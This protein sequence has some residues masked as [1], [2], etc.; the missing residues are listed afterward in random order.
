M[1]LIV[2]E[3]LEYQDLRGMMKPTLHVDEFASKMGDD[4]DIIVLSFFL[5]DQFAARDLMHW[6][7][8]GYDWVLDADVSPGEIRPN[9][10]LVYV[11]MRRRSTAGSNIQ[12]M[13]ED[14][15]TLTELKPS[16]WIMHYRDKTQPFSQEAFDATVPL[17]PREY[18]RQR[19]ESNNDIRTL[20]GIE[21]KSL[22]EPD[23]ELR[24]LQAAAGI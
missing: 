3:A 18:R 2:T 23:R 4:E 1:T 20:A 21:P 12:R 6:F 5:R 24:Q 11:E 14:L 15:E 19:E 7:E 9:R 17:S 13:I 22:G 10:Y 8:K 16:Q